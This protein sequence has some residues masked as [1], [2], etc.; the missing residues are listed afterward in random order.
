MKLTSLFSINIDGTGAYDIKTGI[1]FF[2]HML[3]QFSRHSLIDITLRAKG[4]LYIDDHHTVEDVGI[5]LG[6]SLKNALTDKRGLTR[7]G[8]FML[9]MDDARIEAALDLSNSAVF[10]V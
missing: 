1:G 8:S 7:Y 6:E 2:D 10:S 5:A 4:D 9:V 3:D